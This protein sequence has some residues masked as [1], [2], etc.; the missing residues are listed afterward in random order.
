MRLFLFSFIKVM[1]F[2]PND[3][4]EKIIDQLDIISVIMLN[5]TCKA[6]NNHI[7][8]KWK[9]SKHPIQYLNKIDNI[10]YNYVCL[11]KMIDDIV[12]EVMISGSHIF[13]EY[14][15]VR[16]QQLY[17][18]QLHKNIKNKSMY[19]VIK[20]GGKLAPYFQFIYDPIQE[21]YIGIRNIYGDLSVPMLFVFVGCKV[22]FKIHGYGDVKSF[23]HLPVW[24]LKALFSKKYNGMLYKDIVNG[25]VTI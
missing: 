7:G 18:L 20:K 17:T 14:T 11:N 24:F 5:S 19:F 8:M 15:T 25:F 3:I 16:H 4:L 6:V 10:S 12:H 13:K 9:M 22:L 1:H 2:L 21:S 23:S